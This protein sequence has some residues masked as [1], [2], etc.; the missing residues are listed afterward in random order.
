[1]RHDIIAERA[2]SALP[3]SIGTSLALESLLKPRQAP[4]DSSRVVPK[5]IEAS[6]YNAI[7]INLMTLVRNLIGSLPKTYQESVIPDEIIPALLFEVETIETIIKEDLGNQFKPIFYF[8]D[9]KRLIQAMMLHKTVRF[10]LPNT[11]KQ[12]HYHDILVKVIQGVMKERSGIYL[13]SDIVKP[14]QS[15]NKAL[16]ITH[17][18]YDL[19]AYDKFNTLHLLESHTGKLKTR[20]D[21][22]SKYYPVGELDISM[23]PFT[24]KLLLIFGDHVLIQPM[25]IKF[26]K[27]IQEIAVKRNFHPLMTEE[28]LRMQLDL[29]IKERYLFELYNK[30]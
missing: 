2:V 10:R 13:T 8:N 16:I 18:P 15:T 14:E 28:N 29:G 7:W 6:Q 21:W 25:D 17:V 11:P 30:L 9:Y 26:R 19:T 23:I 20:K 27:L 3:L 5:Q 22:S 4:Y 24:R 1:M 12:I